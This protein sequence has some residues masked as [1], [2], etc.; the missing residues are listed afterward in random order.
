M[1]ISNELL[2]LDVK[3]LL[4]TVINEMITLKSMNLNYKLQTNKMPK[5]RRSEDEENSG[6]HG[7]LKTHVSQKEVN[8]GVLQVR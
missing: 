7:L 6:G 2:L 8:M 1:M 4:E 3:M 5:R